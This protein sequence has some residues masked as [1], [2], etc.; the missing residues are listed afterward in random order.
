[1]RTSLF[2]A[3][4]LLFTTYVPPAWANG[5]DAE[6]FTRS[7]RLEAEGNYA[8][9]LSAL[10]Q[11]SSSWKKEYTTLLRQGWLAYLG[12]D[13]PGAIEAYERAIRA[14]PKAVEP[15]LGVMLPLIAM[16]N[17]PAA[18]KHGDGALKLDPQNYLALSRTAF[19]AFNLGRYADAERRYRRTLEL[20]PSVVEMQA[21]LAWTLLKS[22]DGKAAATIFRRV[23]TLAPAYQ[24]ARTGL[25]MAQQ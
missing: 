22:G 24:S 25:E 21:G 20:Y 10:D 18:L 2:L 14:E 9:A 12:A 11:L 7:Y 16:R 1:M 3:L 5:A 19:A 8:A 15:R 23:V 17:W 4:T 6:V 13:Y